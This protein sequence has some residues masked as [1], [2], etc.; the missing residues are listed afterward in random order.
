MRKSHLQAMAPEDSC[1]V[2]FIVG[3]LMGAGGGGGGGGNECFDN[4][5]L[6]KVLDSLILR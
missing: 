4:H 6:L 1:H 5:L 2:S 3:A